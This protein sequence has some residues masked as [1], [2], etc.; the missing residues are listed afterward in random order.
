MD[1][2]AESERQLEEALAEAEA[3]RAAMASLQ[4]QYMKAQAAQ[5][6][7]SDAMRESGK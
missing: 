4:E 3:R 2:R 7:E 1:R 5:E 6:R